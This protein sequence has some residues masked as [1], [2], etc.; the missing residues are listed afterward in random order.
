MLIDTHAHLDF[1]ELSGDLEGVLRRARE[2]GV[3]QII[4]IGIDLPSSRRAMELARNY[5]CIHSTIGIHPHNAHPLSDG[6]LGDLLEMAKEEKVLA[7]GE[8]GL[9]Y[10]RNHQPR[11]IQR[12]CLRQQL[13]LACSARLP[14]VFHI[15]DAFDDFLDIAPGFVSRL[16]GLVLHCFSGDW[17][18]AKRCLD[19]G[20]YLSIPGTVTFPKAANQ[21]EVAGRAP[22]ERLL[23]E[24]DSPYLAPVPFRGKNNE[25]SY[26]IHTARKVAELRGEAIEEVS[27]VTT[28]NAHRVF[29]IGDPVLE[30]PEGR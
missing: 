27:G 18:T 29:G 23:L 10:F 22:L 6:S 5:P 8:I 28:G 19:L 20:A 14:V 13:E 30:S 1:P 11:D 7:I 15:R 26:L 9:D 21:R 3:L 24:T 2:N 16:P 4:A 12:E 17:P 25:P